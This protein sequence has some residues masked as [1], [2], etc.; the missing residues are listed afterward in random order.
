MSNHITQNIAAVPLLWI[1]PLAIYLLTFILCFDGKGWYRRELFLAMLAAALGVMAW[2]LADP[3]LTHELAIQIGVFCGGLFLACMFCH[4]EL[5]RLKP[6]PAYLTRFY[7]MISL[8]GAL[9]SALVGIVAPLVLPAYFELAVGLV[10]AALLLLWQVRRGHIVFGALA[11]A[12]VLATA[13]CA[14]WAIVEFYDDT[15]VATRN[16]YGVLRVQEFGRD[17]RQPP[18]VADPR[19]DPARHA[20]PGAGVPRGGRRPTTR[21]RRASAACSRCCI[22]ATKPLKVGVIGLGTGTLATYGAKGD[23]YRFYDINPGRDQDRAAR[24]HVPR[25]TATRRSRSSLGDARLSLEREPP[26]QFDVLVDRRVLE[27]RDPGA[28]HHVRGA[29]RLPAAHEARRR[30]RVPRHQPLPEPRPGRRGPRARARPARDPHRGRRRGL[31]REPQ[32]LG[33]AVRPP[34]IAR[35]ARR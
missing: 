23:V 31:A 20:V 12:A 24:L 1:V 21:R 17:T 16:F 29:R 3:K 28:P 27:R 7:L 8:G 32:R 2:T 25:R 10:V 14:V 11:V 4:G 6:A 18:P 15:I 22:P 19:H 9:G 33:A 26:Q 13:G 35:Q 34:R 5:V 30:H